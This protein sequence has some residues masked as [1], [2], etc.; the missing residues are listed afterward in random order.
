M[1]ALH[2]VTAPGHRTPF[3][4]LLAPL[5][6]AA[7]AACDAPDSSDGGVRPDGAVDAGATQCERDSDCGGSFC[8]P[9]SCTPGA[10]ADARGC[11]S[12]PPPCEAGE[13]CSDA[14]QACVSA[15]CTTPD[16]DGDGD[17]SIACGGA[18]CD[19][20]DPLRYS[21]NVEVC[22]AEG[23]DEDCE[24]TTLGEV[25]EDGDGV[26]SAACCNGATCGLDCDDGLRSVGPSQMELCNAIDDDCDGEIDGVDAFCP[27]GMCI[28]QRCQTPTWEYTY[29]S[30]GD[31]LWFTA[32]VDARANVYLGALLGGSGADLNGDASP[33]A[34]GSYLLSLDSTGRQRWLIEAPVGRGALSGDGEH[35]VLLSETEIRYLRTSDGSEDGVDQL[36][37]FDRWDELRIVDATRVGEELV[38]TAVVSVLDL[39][40]DPE[41]PGE[42]ILAPVE[43]A[44]LLVRYDRTRTEVGRRLIESPGS[45]VDFQDTDGSRNYLAL[46]ASGRG[47][48]MV[49]PGQSFEGDFLLVMGRDLSTVWARPVDRVYR[50]FV[51]N[52]GRAVISGAFDP[53][54]SPPWS[55]STYDPF[56]NGSGARD[57]FVTSFAANGDHL[58]TRVHSGPD[59]DFFFAAP[60]DGRQGLVLS[61]LFSGEMNVAPGGTLGAPDPDPPSPGTSCEGFFAELGVDDGQ[62]FTVSATAISGSGCERV[63][64]VRNDDFGGSVAVG[65]YDRDVRLPSGT[66]YPDDPGST[67]NLFVFR[68]AD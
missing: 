21:G 39:V 14:D 9:Q 22:D 31:D 10:G 51:S 30:D 38:V 54:W 32:E 41:A 25:D 16:R 52:E 37:L 67:R 53:P 59:V 33:E 5:L 58:W 48:T 66:V 11:V 47:P 29:G 18:D 4:L 34:P 6:V 35:I 62:S 55:A 57:A 46:A 1:S 12:G 20:D 23:R 45:F 24:P 3:G 17:P 15:D 60:F 61:G 19:D 7:L 64:V 28:G 26:L 13:T 63:L 27:S 65:D 44:L 68:T 42:T 56:P 8:A 40:P 43:S 49:G 36:A 50:A 2:W